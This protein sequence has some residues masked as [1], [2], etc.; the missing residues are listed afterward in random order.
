MLVVNEVTTLNKYVKP[1][2]E[3]IYLDEQPKLLSGSN[4]AGFQDV[5]REDW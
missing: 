1:E 5:D 4:G 2:I 3:V